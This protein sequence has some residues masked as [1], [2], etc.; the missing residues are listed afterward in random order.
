MK[1]YFVA[2]IRIH[3]EEEYRIYLDSVDEVF[4]GYRGKYLAVDD[5][6]VVLEGN[7]EYTK[8]VIIEFDSR[9]DF[10]D[11]YYSEK[12]QD[13]LVHRLSASVCDSILVEGSD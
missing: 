13:L 10:E 2:N 12:Y 1:Y 11:W 5:N 9:K 4:S 8:S 3:N 6:P 7:W